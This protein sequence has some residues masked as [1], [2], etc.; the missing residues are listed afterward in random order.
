LALNNWYSNSRKTEIKP[1]KDIK[2]MKE[3]KIIPWGRGLLA[4]L[5]A[6]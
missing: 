1:R 4:K 2:D 5:T 6:A 3:D